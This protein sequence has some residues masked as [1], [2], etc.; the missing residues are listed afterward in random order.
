MLCSRIR[1]TTWKHHKV[2]A[3]KS[4][5]LIKIEASLEA[6]NKAAFEGK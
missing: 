2:I 5:T 4:K 1:A 3:K 6:S